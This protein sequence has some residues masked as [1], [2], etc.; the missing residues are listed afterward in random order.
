MVSTSTKLEITLES[1]KVIKLTLEEAKQLSNE[2][3]TFF[4]DQILPYDPYTPY[5]YNPFEPST[6]LNPYEPCITFR[7]T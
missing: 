3:K 5:P 7:N 1:G 4:K 2:L 6:P